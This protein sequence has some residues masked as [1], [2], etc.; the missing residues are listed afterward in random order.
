VS[1]AVSQA[2]FVT[3]AKLPKGNEM[4]TIVP[5]KRADG[6]T[7]F[8][9]RIRIK[10]GGEIVYSESETFEKRHRAETWLEDREK[11]L[12]KPGA[13][14]RARGDDPPLGA[15]IDRYVEESFEAIGR[16]KAQVLR[17]IKKYRIAKLRCSEIE[18]A[19]VVQLATDLRKDGTRTG[20]TVQNYLS[21][22]SAVFAIAR[23]SWK[24]P[25]NPVAMEDAFTACRKRKITMK[26]RERDRR[27]TIAEI[28]KL[29]EL[30]LRAERAR[31][32]SIPMAKITLFAMFATRRQE[33]I[34][35]LRWPDLET[36]PRQRTLVRD[37]KH[38]GDKV[39]NDVWCDVPPE[40]MR[41]IL[42]MP[43]VSECIFPYNHKTISAR[44]T[45]ACQKLGIVDL[46]FHDLRHEG[47]SRLFEMGE[48]IPHVAAVSGHRSWAS[49]KRY[50]Q[51]QQ[52]G[53]KWAG[54]K[55]LDLV[56]YVSVKLRTAA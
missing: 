53:D 50:T 6:S 16:T 5:R 52:R 34:T 3:P 19:D 8:L 1:Q 9:A 37:M 56:C 45:R 7:A 49:L 54:W 29:I 11:E 43:R 18:S 4:G 14:E 44:F 13:M 27:P 36:E 46:H 31:P 10:E 32:G 40:A 12:A 39:G 26:A 20:Q 2:F 22:L 41:V 25:L 15:V 24:Y 35:T 17:A 23:P 28:D 48:S 51:L 30:F 47:I 33:E 42:S 55:G 38:P 21:H